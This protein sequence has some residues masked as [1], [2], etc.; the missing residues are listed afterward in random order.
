MHQQNQFVNSQTREKVG[1][2]CKE[3]RLTQSN[4]LDR[5]YLKVA[6]SGYETKSQNF[7]DFSVF[8]QSYHKQNEPGNIERHHFY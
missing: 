6:K 7:A 3:R 2:F 8:L 4:C 5:R 1:D